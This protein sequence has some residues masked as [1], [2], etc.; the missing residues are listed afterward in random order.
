MAEPPPLVTLTTD[1]GEGSRYVAAMKGALLRGNPDVRL[2]DISHSVPPQDVVAG[3]LLLAET[4]PW[5]P[6]KTLHVVVVDPGVGSKRRIL[7]VE[8]QDQRLLLPDNGLMSCLADR[9]KPTRMLVLENPEIWHDKVSATFH[10]RDVFA[11]V[12]ARLSLGFAPEQLGPPTTQLITIPI[13]KAVRVGQKIE[14]EVVEIDSFG[15]LVTDIGEDLLDGV[16]R[17]EQVRVS[18][19][20]HETFGIFTTYAD[21]PSMTLIALIGSGG[22]LELA[23]VDESASIMLGVRRGAKVTVEW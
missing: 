19:D 12:A 18:C 4:V 7:Y 15:N 22:K 5:F 8:W 1:F 20:E 23:I 6:S 3:A 11:P 17:D 16:P 14:G 13:A 9:A 21:Q 10:G 2:V